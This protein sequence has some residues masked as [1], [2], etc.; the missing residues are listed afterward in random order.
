MRVEG[1]DLRSKWVILPG[2]L[3]KRCPKRARPSSS[4]S[5]VTPGYLED[6]GAA[7]AIKVY[8]KITR[9]LNIS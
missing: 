9:F 1:Q 2:M 8:Q 3:T 7:P 4:T 6:A 5:S